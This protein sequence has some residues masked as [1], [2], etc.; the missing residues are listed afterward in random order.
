MKNSA[1]P[2]SFEDDVINTTTALRSLTDKSLQQKV[3]LD[4]ALNRHAELRERIKVLQ[5]YLS[6]LTLQL[7]D[8]PLE[9]ISR[10]ENKR[11]EYQD[12][13]IKLSTEKGQ[14]EIRLDVL[15]KEISQLDR[16]IEEADKNEDK[17][18]IL[19][20]RAK[21]A[22]RAAEATSDVYQR[23][24]GT[25]RQ[26]IEQKASEIFKSLISK[27]GHF[28]FVKLGEDYRLEVFDRYGSP[29]VLSYGERQVLSLS[30]ITAMARISEEE[31]PLV[32]D[33]PFGRLDET[34]R[35]SVTEHLPELSDQLVLFV[36]DTELVGR[37]R[38]NLEPRVGAE[39][40]LAFN[41]TTSCTEIV[42]VK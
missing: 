32:M 16:Q 36:T 37:A 5:G 2:T 41:D 7:K 10:L 23:F 4:K 28:Q 13:I 34:H 39:Y 15:N 1:L 30:F 8:I 27:I 29:S 6:D 22:Q 9:N 33:T 25:M 18:H 19:T 17:A 12:S 21:L 14:I 11:Q 40:H 20:V 26:Q 24:A 3:R 42:K 38:D 31:A 35:E